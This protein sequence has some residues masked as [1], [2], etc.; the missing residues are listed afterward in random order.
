M[1]NDI[2][3][4]IEIWDRIK[5]YIPAAKREDAAIQLISSFTEQDYDLNLKELKGNDDY[6]DDAID[7]LNEEDDEEYLED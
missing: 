2:S 5:E 1:N 6:L 3:L 4:V 7:I